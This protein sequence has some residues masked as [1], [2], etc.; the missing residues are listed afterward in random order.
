MLCCCVWFLYAST[1]GENTGKWRLPVPPG[2]EPHPKKRDFP[3]KT[4]EESKN[5]HHE[6]YRNPSSR[7]RTHHFSVSFF[8]GGYFS[9]GWSCQFFF[10]S[11]PANSWSWVT[12][13]HCRRLHGALVV[14]LTTHSFSG[15]FLAHG[16]IYIDFFFWG[17][18]VWVVALTEQG[19]P[20]SFVCINRGQHKID[21]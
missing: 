21:E 5:T 8:L 15:F 1:I 19:R 3:R 14:S 10:N 17:D 12:H 13:P 18:W 2:D 9:R 6:C 11:L 4:E 20:S 7:T 16:Y